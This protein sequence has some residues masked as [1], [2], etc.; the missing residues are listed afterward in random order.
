MSFHKH[1]LDNG[2]PVIAELS[3]DVHSSAVGF[4]VRTGS[5]DESP[6]IAGVSHFLEHMVFK[7]T[8]K[9]SADDVNRIFD[10]IGAKYNAS[11]SEE[12]TLFYAAVLPEYLPRAFELLAS[13]MQP[14]LR[15]D[16]FDME[17]QVILEEILMYED[18]PTFSAYEK[19]MASHFADHPLGNSILG[20]N[21]SITDLTVDQMRAY[22][23]SRYQTANIT[24][25]V[26]GRANWAEVLRLAERHCSNWP[27][28]IPDRRT[29][30]AH[31][32]GQVEVFPREGSLQQHVMQIAAAPAAA[33]DLRFAADLLSVIVGDDAGS[34]LYWE[35]VDPGHA[36]AAEVGYN[37]YDGSGT[38]MTYLSCAPEETLTN[39]GRIQSVYERVNQEGVSEDE[40][41][42]ARNKALSRIVLRS[43]RP[44]GRLSSLGS[45]WVYRNEYRSVTDDLNAYRAITPDDIRRLLERYPLAQTTT[46]AV[47]PLES[48]V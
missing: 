20:S 14:T 30:E 28:G 25:A 39:L 1:Y 29:D 27:Q 16:D 13:L 38:W 24:L 17:K 19:V 8:E 6:E 21:Q 26:T 3:D 41:E 5:R 44:M 48:L 9:Y 23:A 36:E 12:I 2:L 43:E 34:R 15:S 11:T 45:N 18:M 4:F 35:L 7:G 47:G 42:Q 32:V 46:V 37:E 33:D 40:L 31:A 22:H 10:E